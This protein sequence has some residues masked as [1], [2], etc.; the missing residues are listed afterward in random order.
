MQDPSPDRKKSKKRKE[1]KKEKEA[2]I[3]NK[4]IRTKHKTKGSTPPITMKYIHTRNWKKNNLK[5]KRG[6]DGDIIPLQS[7]LEVL[8]VWL[9]CQFF[10]CQWILSLKFILDLN[11]LIHILWTCRQEYELLEAVQAKLVVHPLTSPL[12]GSDHKEFR[13]RGPQVCSLEFV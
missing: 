2:D 10:N 13:G 8:S 5:E 1:R 11:N 3:P 7:N 4:Y 12:L 9:C 6:R